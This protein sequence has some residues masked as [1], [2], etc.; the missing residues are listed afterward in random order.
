MAKPR[1]PEMTGSQ[2]RALRR[3]TGLSQAKFAELVGT[4]A[5][6]VARWERGAVRISRPMAHSVIFVGMM[7]NDLRQMMLTKFQ[8]IRDQRS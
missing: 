6:T 4:T 1:P 3:R 8:A 2:L 7:S 5:N